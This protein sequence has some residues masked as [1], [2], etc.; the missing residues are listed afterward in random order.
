MFF[1]PS[2]DNRFD[3]RSR[4]GGSARSVRRAPAWSWAHGV[5]AALLASSALLAACQGCRST[6]GVG[7]A[8]G[9]GSVATESGS[10]TGPTV[11]LYLTSDLAGALEPCG[12]TKDQLGGL[13]HAAA[14]MR[15]EKPQAANA[16]LVTAG[17]LFFM[18]ATLK[19]DHRDQDITKAETIAASLKSL[20]FAAFAPGANEWAAGDAELAKL[21]A[22]SGG[23]MLLANG[24]AGAPG[25]DPGWV[26][27][28]IGGVKVGFLGV[29]GGAAPAQT[30][31]AT[32]FPV[33]TSPPADAITRGMDALKKQGVSIF[34]ALAAVGRG[35]AKRLADRV[36]G[37]TAILVGSPGGSGDQNSPASPPERIGDVLV[38]ET[39]NHLTNVGVLDLFVRGSSFAFADGTGLELGQKREELRRHI[40]DLRGRIAQWDGDPAVKKEDL[41][42]RRAEVTKLE[43]ELKALDVRPAPPTGSY[44]RYALQDIRAS[45]GT[46]DEV[47]KAATAYYKQINDKNRIAFADRVAPKPGPGE[48]S[49]VGVEACTKCHKEAREVWDGTRHATAYKTLA[50]E[51][52]QFN[53]DCVSCHVTGYERPGGSTVVHVQKLENVGCEVCHG[54]GSKHSADPKH[55]KIAI[56]KPKADSCLACHHPPHVEGF[57]A[58]AKMAGI[59]GPG[60][61][62]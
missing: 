31:I 43:S 50:D 23:A 35:E 12:C 44:F 9:S 17:P 21:Q 7:S 57:D 11:R 25:T 29:S 55:V 5:G 61:G 30:S 34:V 8:G 15:S 28:T 46:D 27:R 32:P 13:D 40:D 18:D 3:K 54:P 4:S 20:G 36:P 47:K 59:L 48:S 24:P 6:P 52:K 1:P 33:T 39:G 10:G 16:V 22:A 2:F 58:E 49:Y 14:W 60:H 38:L 53:L 42:A 41:D 26:V 56:E 62:L 45:L 37:L 51:D 19:P